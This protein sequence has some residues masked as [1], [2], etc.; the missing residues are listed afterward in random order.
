MD[1]FVLGAGFSKAIFNK[2]PLISDFIKIID[3]IDLP[4]EYKTITN[5]EE[6]LSALIADYPWKTLSE[7]HL[8]ESKYYEITKLLSESINEIECNIVKENVP[9]WAFKIVRYFLIN[10]KK[11]ITFNYDTLIERILSDTLNKT[12][13]I[14][15]LLNIYQSS[16]INIRSRNDF[17]WGN[18]NS[19][20]DM[21]LIKIHGSLNWY[22]SPRSQQTNFYYT[23]I[24]KFTNKYVDENN[25]AKYALKDLECFIIPPIHDKNN[26]FDSGFVYSLWKDFRKIIS[27][28]TQLY[29]IG[30]SLPESDFYLNHFLSTYT[31]KDCEIFIVNIDSNAEKLKQTFKQTFG[32]RKIFDKYI[33]NDCIKRLVDDLTINNR[34]H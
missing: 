30:Y 11:V 20:S 15:E 26:L 8:H 12:R 29:F 23:P 16:I 27:N 2:M 21:Q 7:K 5:F 14:N 33:S 9:S 25:A 3:R 31:N 10:S 34:Y 18:I 4:D 17:T 28:S 24:Y 13:E 19:T 1:S 22:Y 32:K 6:L